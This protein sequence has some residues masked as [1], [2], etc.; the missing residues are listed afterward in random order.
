MTG[1]AIV[2][3]GISGLAAAYYLSRGQIP[4][5]LFECRER[6]GGLL[7]TER[8][9]GCLLE[10]GPDSWLAEKRWMRSFVE[11]LGLGAQVIGSNDRRKRTY[12]VRDE[13]LVPLPDSMRMLA[14]AK[15]WQILTTRLFGPAAKARIIAEWFHRPGTR[16]DRS[17][18]EFVREHFG[19]EAVAYLAQPMMAGVYG[20]QPDHL[21]AMQVMP[22][23][24]EYERR[25]GSILRGTFRNRRRRMDG[26]LFLT[27]RDGLGSLVGALERRIEE[28]C[29]VVHRRVLRVRRQGCRWTLRLDEGSFEA[30]AVILAVPAHEAGRLLQGEIPDLAGHLGTIRYTSSV[31]VALSYRRD[32]FGHPLDGFG[33]LVPSI[34]RASVAACTWVG[35][36][37]EGRAGP[38]RVLLRAFLTGDRA[39]EALQADDES[40]ARMVAAELRGWMGFD[41]P[42]L[43][44]RVYRWPGSM[45]AYGVGHDRLVR[46][47]EQ[48]LATLPGLLLAGNGYT[49]LG[50]PDCIRRSRQLAETIIDARRRRSKLT[51]GNGGQS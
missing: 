25:Y 11:E 42:L 30:D 43:G 1:V 32:D 36:K 5:T 9:H 50:I 3:G 39:K 28:H 13:R 48:R 45:P 18:A 17:V 8:A 26:P 21:S 37:F 35:T 14:P 12:V 40:V 51:Q 10:A 49:G 23:F 47:I 4:C 44:S 24:V 34:E 6:T 19:T 38:D 2:G 33:F 41:A 29:E 27:L 22:R 46:S 16:P 15:P 31:V 20:A 7:R